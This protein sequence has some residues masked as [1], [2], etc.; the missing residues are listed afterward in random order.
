[1]LAT[2]SSS[3]LLHFAT[4]RAM[5]AG[6]GNVETAILDGEHLDVEEA[7]FDAVI[8]RLGI[9]YF[10]DQQAALRGMWRALKPGGKL[11]GIVYSTA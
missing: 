3:N 4:Q 9:M 7:S 11:A 8:S 5:E 10:P 6:F 2:D 1:M